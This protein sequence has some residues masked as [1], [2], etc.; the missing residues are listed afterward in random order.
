[1][2][3]TNCLPK[4]QLIKLFKSVGFW[5]E[6]GVVHNLVPQNRQIDNFPTSKILGK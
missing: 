1:M 3:S 6:S 5:I 2:S 4:P